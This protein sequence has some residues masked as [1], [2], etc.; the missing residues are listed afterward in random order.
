VTTPE[1]HGWAGNLP[2]DYEQGR[3]C[4]ASVLIRELILRL[5]ARGVAAPDN[6]IAVF[7]HFLGSPAAIGKN[8]LMAFWEGGGMRQI[9]ELLREALRRQ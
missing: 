8:A 2:A 4:I 6:P 3:G 1:C 9:A 5:C 7:C